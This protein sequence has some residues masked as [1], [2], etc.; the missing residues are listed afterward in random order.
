VKRKLLLLV[1]AVAVTAGVVAC[2]IDDPC[3]EGQ[4]YASYSC[5]DI[6]M[7]DAGLDAGGSGGD[8]GGE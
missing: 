4:I 5:I 3:D 1:A 2:D 8:A 7:P 6:P